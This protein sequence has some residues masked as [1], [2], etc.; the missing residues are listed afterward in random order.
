MFPSLPPSPS[1]SLSLPHKPSLRPSDPFKNSLVNNS[2]VLCTHEF[3]AIEKQ[4]RKVFCIKTASKY[5]RQT[6]RKFGF[7]KLVDEGWITTV[8]DLE[9]WRFERSVRANREIVGCCKSIW[10][11][12]G[13]LPLV[14]IWWH[15]FVNKLVEWEEF[16]HPVCIVLFWYAFKG[17]PKNSVS[18]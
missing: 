13:A 2:W 14:E 15:K 9:S 17:A 6:K 7:I 5:I 18:L 11:C 16:I 3:K 10:E 4:R 1:L 8:K 12:G